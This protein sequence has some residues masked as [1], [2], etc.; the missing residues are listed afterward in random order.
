METLVFD[1]WFAGNVLALTTI[2][3]RDLNSILRV[4]L[5]NKM[6][7]PMSKINDTQRN[8]QQCLIF[9]SIIPPNVPPFP[10]YPSLY[11]ESMIILCVFNNLQLTSRKI[12]DRSPIN[13]DNIFIESQH[14]MDS[15]D[16]VGNYDEL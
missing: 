1:I 11:C 6:Q 14:E 3:Y 2:K 10:G 9:F 7:F 4:V 16:V 5:W 12:C 8:L 15:V 13:T